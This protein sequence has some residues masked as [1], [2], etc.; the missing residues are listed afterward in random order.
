[1]PQEVTGWSFFCVLEAPLLFKLTSSYSASL[2]WGAFQSQPSLHGPS[3][4]L[5]SEEKATDIQGS[6]ANF[7]K[8][9]GP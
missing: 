1:M 2:P 4:V 7:A 8:L 6:F 5:C 3:F 9:K